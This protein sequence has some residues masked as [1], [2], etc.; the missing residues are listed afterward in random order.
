MSNNI[1]LF[2]SSYHTIQP[3]VRPCRIWNDLSKLSFQI[4][5][6]VSETAAAYLK[7]KPVYA[8]EIIMVC[9]CFFIYNPVPPA[10]APAERIPLAPGARPADEP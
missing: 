1:S 10:A 8:A 7:E 6:D 2:F 9:A 5:C 3:A 4:L